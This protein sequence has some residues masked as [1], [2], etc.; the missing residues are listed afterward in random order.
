MTKMV[1]IAVIA[2]AL[3]SVQAYGEI[4]PVNMILS[5]FQGSAGVDNGVTT[6]EYGL[7]GYDVDNHYSE[8]QW[9]VKDTAGGAVAVT[10]GWVIMLEDPGLDPRLSMN[11]SDLIRFTGSGTGAST[12]T[13]FSA[14][15]WTPAAVAAVQHPTVISEIGEAYSIYT[16]TD[17][18][19]EPGFY[20]G[21]ATY[22]VVSDVPEPS[23]LALLPMA[24]FGLGFWRR[25]RKGA[26]A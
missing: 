22:N 18:P 9:A 19:A 10:D 1:W 7:R 13:L 20:S 15:D 25:S 5:E 14:D 11:W 24:L 8:W 3:C 17:H 4:K 23:S 16:P 21:G 26:V 6:P 2:V 12:V